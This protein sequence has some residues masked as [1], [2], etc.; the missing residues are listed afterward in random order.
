MTTAGESILKGAQDALAYLQGDESKGRSHT[1]I[2]TKVD[3]KSIREEIGLTQVKFAETYG[4]SLSTLK[5]WETGNREPEGAA[6]AYLTVISQS[7]DAVREALHS[8]I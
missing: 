4:L 1:I 3:V 7:P 5:K 2:T 8:A 6:K